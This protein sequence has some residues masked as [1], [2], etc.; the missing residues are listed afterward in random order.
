[1]RLKGLGDAGLWLGGGYEC[2]HFWADP[3]RNFV[4]VIMSQNNQVKSPGYEMNDKF[5]GL[6]YK[7]LFEIE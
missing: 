6:L 5:K 1:M 7:A 2:T 3:K 4:G